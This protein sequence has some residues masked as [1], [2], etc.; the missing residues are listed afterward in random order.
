MIF[1]QDD[2]VIV[3]FISEAKVDTDGTH[4]YGHGVLDRAEDGYVFGRLIDTGLP[5]GCPERYVQMFEPNAGDFV[6]KSVGN[7]CSVFEVI[8]KYKVSKRVN[9]PYK[10]RIKNI[11]TH[12]ETFVSVRGIDRLASV[13]EV[14]A[15]YRHGTPNF[16]QYW[17][18]QSEAE[19]IAEHLAYQEELIPGGATLV[20][21]SNFDKSQ[22]CKIFK[23]IK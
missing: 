16:D 11:K 7:T 13:N 9:S 2:H 17:Y 15:G 1:K 23:E 5:F 20:T 18:G 21:G 22:L 4:V 12:L 10:Y 19:A 8:G 3:D 6:L 14:V